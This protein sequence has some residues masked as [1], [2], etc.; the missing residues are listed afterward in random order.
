VER[1]GAVVAQIL[2][3]LACFVF[4][5]FGVQSFVDARRKRGG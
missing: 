3:C 1:P 2:M 5:A 4:V